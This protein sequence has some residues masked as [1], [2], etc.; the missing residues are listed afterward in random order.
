MQ[1]TILGRTNLTVSRMGLGAG[2][3]SRLG[4][5]TGGGVPQDYAYLV[6]DIYPA[7]Q[8]AQQQGKIRFGGLSE[9]MFA[10]QQGTWQPRQPAR[11][12]VVGR[13]D[14]ALSSL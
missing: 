2:G 14:H 11:S 12:P 10:V 13:V 3:H 5:N 1:T 7:L 4:R 6:N 9:I 8:K